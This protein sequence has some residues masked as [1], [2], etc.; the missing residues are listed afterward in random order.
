M[1]TNSYIYKLLLLAFSIILSLS[2]KLFLSAIISCHFM[3]IS[4]NNHLTTH[5]SYPFF[6]IIPV[7]LVFDI[8]PALLC[9][10]SSLL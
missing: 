5:H 9:I 3:C 1:F 2:F 8:H 4:L 10:R 7:S 6:I